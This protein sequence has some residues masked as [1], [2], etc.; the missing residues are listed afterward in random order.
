MI[1]I[2]R[3]V[4]TPYSYI[5]SSI[6]ERNFWRGRSGKGKGRGGWVSWEW[7][8]EGVSSWE[9]ANLWG[10]W[11][12]SYLRLNLGVW[13]WVGPFLECFLRRSALCSLLCRS[14]ISVSSNAV[15]LTFSSETTRDSFGRNTTFFWVRGSYNYGDA[16]RWSWGAIPVEFAQRNV[17][18]FV[19]EFA[20][21][22][23]GGGD[24]QGLK[25]QDGHFGIGYFEF[26]GLAKGGGFA[27]G[28]ACSYLGRTGHLRV[29]SGYN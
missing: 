27:S 23:E 17:P 2:P 15:Y 28:G 19:F 4:E 14:S 22:F 18:H 16:S 3:T 20:C 8:G 1:P 5:R 26:D 11:K 6:L 9:R 12:G 29:S 10:E 24:A 13:W 25:R 7:R 21:A